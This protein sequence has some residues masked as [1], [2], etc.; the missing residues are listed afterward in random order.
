MSRIGEL[1]VVLND[2][3]ELASCEIDA[4]LEDE[5]EREINEFTKKKETIFAEVLSLSLSLSISLFLI[6]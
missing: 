1:E 2:L 4:G 3:E 5:I 6:N